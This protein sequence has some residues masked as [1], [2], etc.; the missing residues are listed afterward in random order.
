[1]FVVYSLIIWILW[2]FHFFNCFAH[3]FASTFC[4]VWIG[5]YTKSLGARRF[6]RFSFPYFHFLFY[7]QILLDLLRNVTFSKYSESSI[8]GTV[9]I[10]VS[11][12]TL[13]NPHRWKITGLN[14]NITSSSL[15]LVHITM[16]REPTSNQVVENPKIKIHNSSFGGS[17]LQPDTE[18]EVTDCYIDGAHKFI[19]YW[20]I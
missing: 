20:S 8:V 12:V 18:A 17:D 3:A 5:F 4:S 14:V 15:S 2:C 9:V 6:N 1:M 10:T 19:L 11:N 16:R 7:F 13:A